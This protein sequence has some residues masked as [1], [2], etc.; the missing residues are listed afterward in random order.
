M[1]ARVDHILE[2]ALALAVEERTAL[3]V[4]LLESLESSAD[5]AISEAWRV[6]IGRRRAALCGGEARPLIWNDAKARLLSL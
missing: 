2:E 1:N 5:A 3:A 6:E 4:A